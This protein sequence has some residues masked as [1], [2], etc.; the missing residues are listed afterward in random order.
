MTSFGALFSWEQ[1]VIYM[2][3]IC[4]SKISKID[5]HLIL[6]LRMFEGFSIFLHYYLVSCFTQC[7]EFLPLKSLLGAMKSF[8]KA[9]QFQLSVVTLQSIPKFWS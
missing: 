7:L 1:A 8:L 4:A 6:L 5:E 3:V 9:Q 2:L